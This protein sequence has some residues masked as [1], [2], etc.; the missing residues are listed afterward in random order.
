MALSKEWYNAE[1][2][3]SEKKH[4]IVPQVLNIVFIML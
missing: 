3:D 1:F 2:I 4:C